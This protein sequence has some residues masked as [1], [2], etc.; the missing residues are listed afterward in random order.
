MRRLL[1]IIAFCILPFFQWRC[2]NTLQ[3]NGN[4]EEKVVVYGLLNYGQD[5]NYIRIQKTFL[6][7]N[8]SALNLASQA[9]E[10]YYS[11]GELEVKLEQW[12]FGALVNTTF[13]DY[14]DGDTLGIEKDSGVFASSPNILY[15]ICMPLDSSSTY[16]LHILRL[17]DSSIFTAETNLVQSF[18]LFSPT[19][20][21]AYI[22]FADT[23][24]ITYTCKQAVNGMIYDLVMTFRYA[25]V[26]HINGDSTIH[27]IDWVI[28]D[29]KEGTGTIGISNLNYTLSRH[30][31]YS[32]IASSLKV[33]TAVTR[34]AININYAWYAGGIELYDQYLNLLANLGLNEDY[35]SPEYTNVNGGLGIFSSRYIET[36]NNLILDD[37]SLDSLSCGAITRQLRFV[38]SAS[39]HDYPACWEQ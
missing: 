2:D 13:C 12:K 7:E 31:F 25:E 8:T 1:G 17:E 23:G 22:S 18:Y 20:P 29:N 38:G 3:I 21:N 37:I 11:A 34:Y 30:A 39:N 5:T 32:F 28:F 16:K 15:R 10:N 26:R 35:I 33:D 27:S 14:V 9:G 19:K 36:A 4:Y 6:G 24:N